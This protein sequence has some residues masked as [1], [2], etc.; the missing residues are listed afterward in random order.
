MTPSATLL[1]ADTGIEPFWTK[2]LQA[3]RQLA[4]HAASGLLDA[5]FKWRFEA[6]SE[7]ESG[8]SLALTGGSEGRQLRK[9]VTR[10]AHQYCATW[11]AGAVNHL[12][13][14]IWPPQPALARHLSKAK[15]KQCIQAASEAGVWVDVGP[16][17]V[18][19]LQLQDCVAPVGLG[20]DLCISLTS[21]L[22]AACCG[23]CLSGGGQPV[24]WAHHQRHQRAP[25][26]AAGA[27]RLRLGAERGE[28]AVRGAH[29]AAQEGETSSLVPARLRH[30]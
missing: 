12:A 19:E 10:S 17:G 11:L 20:D 15:L 21:S 4:H 24:D 23:G 3:L 13:S 22:P 1:Q 25:G 6:G 7:R 30:S 8:S 5:L 16:Q 29:G 28:L 18:L 2:I 27:D 26:R 9:K 14:Q